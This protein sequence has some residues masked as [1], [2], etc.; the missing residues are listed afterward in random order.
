M[1]AMIRGQ[2]EF[3]RE[4]LR[5]VADSD[6]STFLPRTGPLFVTGCGT[7]FHAAMFGARI[8]GASINHRQV[9]HAVH[10][11]DLAHGRM[12]VRGTVIGVS[13]SGATGT[14][15]R[16]LLRAKQKGLRTVGLCGLTDS[17]MEGIVDDVLVIGSTRDRS[18]AN[19]MAYT[20]ELVAFAALAASRAPRLDGLVHGIPAIPRLVRSTLATEDAVRD[21]ANRLARRRRLT[22]LA[23]GWDDITAL[24]A[25]LKIR[26]TCGLTASGYHTEQFLHGP[27]LSLDRHDAVVLLQSRDDTSRAEEIRRAVRKTGAA[28]TTVGEHPRASIRLPAV[29]AFLRPIVSVIPTQFLAYYTAVGRRANPDIMRT[30]IPRLRAGVEALF[31]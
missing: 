25:A 17:E 19:T 18:W 16:A 31:H 2:P 6:A 20:S 8:L 11:Y 26:E 5:R 22:I 29:H 7:S 13:H 10:A 28:V 21:L 14:T 24:E 15:N 12:T 4:T 1:H 30:D 9:V 23:T 27:F 3:L